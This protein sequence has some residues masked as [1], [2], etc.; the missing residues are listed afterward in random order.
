MT[1]SPT[2]PF[3]FTERGYEAPRRLVK[4]SCAEGSAGL[5]QWPARGGHHGPQRAS[6]LDR[7]AQLHAC[8]PL[9]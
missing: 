7:E 8:V 2:A 9:H 4:A 6:Q 3:S 5:P 1:R